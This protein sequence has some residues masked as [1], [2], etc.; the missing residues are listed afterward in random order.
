MVNTQI[1]KKYIVIRAT[2]FP[3]ILFDVSYK[4]LQIV[5]TGGV[6]RLGSSS[7]TG[8]NNIHSFLNHVI[9]INDIRIIKE[10]MFVIQYNIP[11]LKLREIQLIVICTC[12]FLFIDL[13]CSLQ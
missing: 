7:F 6:M 13:Q 4:Y 3:I 5:L 9:G 1:D 11:F 10:I 8:L 12:Q 2:P